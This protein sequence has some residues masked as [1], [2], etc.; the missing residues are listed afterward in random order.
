MHLRHALQFLLILHG[1]NLSAEYALL[2]IEHDPFNWTGCGIGESIALQKFKKKMYANG[3]KISL[4]SNLRK[5]LHSS[6]DTI[7]V[8]EDPGEAALIA[9]QLFNSKKYYVLCC[10]ETPIT[11][12]YYT[13]RHLKPF[14]A[15]VTYREDLLAIPRKIF[16]LHALYP[17]KCDFQGSQIDWQNKTLATTVITYADIQRIHPPFICLQQQRLAVVHW[18]EN[19]APEDFHGYGHNWPSISI[20]KGP[21]PGT[22]PFNPEQKIEILKK[23]KFCFCFENTA[24]A[25]GYI[26]EKIFHALAAGCIPI[27]CGAPDIARYIP[28]NCYLLF[29]DFSSMEELYDFMKNMSEQ[30]HTEYVEHARQWLESDASDIF[31][32]DHFID[33]MIYLIKNKPKA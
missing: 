21:I 10:F 32:L 24:N 13:A 2:V 31:S 8:F 15:L 28:R 16:R 3:I 22:H 27:Y 12:P 11:M 18:F 1:L 14:N 29:T 19:N 9:P 5:T 26:S 17:E 6:A 25:P 4:R 33:K 23:Y 20:S 30:T 7:I